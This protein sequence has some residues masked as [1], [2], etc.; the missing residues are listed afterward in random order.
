MSNFLDDFW[1]HPNHTFCSFCLTQT[2]LKLTKT[3]YLDKNSVNHARR[4]S[5][6][7]FTNHGVS[8][9]HRVLVQITRFYSRSSR[10][11]LTVNWPAT[12][13]SANFARPSFVRRM[14]PAL[15]SRWILLQRCKY[16]RPLRVYLKM[17][18]ISCSFNWKRE[19]LLIN[20]PESLILRF[21]RVVSWCLRQIPLHSI[22]WQSE[23][24]WCTANGLGSAVGLAHPKVRIFEIAP[25]V[26]DDVRWVALFHDRDF[27]HYLL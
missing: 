7:C 9:C 11:R 5:W 3:V 27:F 6:K 16:S 13:K 4:T 26:F 17:T 24:R 1:C 2:S 21:C 14:F 8:L 22:P 15:I 20:F 12:P 23:R 10:Q 25:E 19:G 18:A